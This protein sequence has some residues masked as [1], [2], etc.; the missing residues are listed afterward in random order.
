M[1]LPEVGSISMSQVNTELKKAGNTQIS[2]NDSDVRKIAKIPSGTISM[3]DLRGKKASEYVENYELYNVRW[4]DSYKNGS[5]TIYFPHKII[6]GTLI[7][8]ARCTGGSY[9]K[10]AN[11]SIGQ[12]T[13]IDVSN[14]TGISGVYHTESYHTQSSNHS[15]KGVINLTVYFTGEWEA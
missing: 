9:V 2:L 11:Q 4:E 3:S 13:R 7:C 10:I 15:K 5:F 14:I 1:A 12:N 6:N 8:N